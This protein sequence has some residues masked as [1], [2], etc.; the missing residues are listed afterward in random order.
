[1]RALYYQKLLSSSRHAAFQRAFLHD[2]KAYL[3][4]LGS[5][6]SLVACAQSR[7]HSRA[8]ASNSLC[9]VFSQWRCPHLLCHARKNMRA[10]HS[11][12]FHFLETF[13]WWHSLS[14]QR[15]D[16]SEVGDRIAGALKIEARSSRLTVLGIAPTFLEPCLCMRLRCGSSR[17]QLIAV[18]P[19]C[20]RQPFRSSERAMSGWYFSWWGLRRYSSTCARHGTA[21]CSYG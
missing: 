8:G 6:R 4:G 15:H 11:I 3:D 21:L 7:K 18:L 20:C 12:A 9:V 14:T 5:V 19:H 13:R 2:F 17:K 1:M 16:L 10:I